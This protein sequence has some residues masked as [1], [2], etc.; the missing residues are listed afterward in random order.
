VPMEGDGGER[1]EDGVGGLVP[2]R[3]TENRVDPL[4]HRWKGMA[5]SMARMAGHEHN[6]GAM[7]AGR[8]RRFS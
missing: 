4:G 1:G 5:G 2:P 7:M 6:T 8:R 3:S